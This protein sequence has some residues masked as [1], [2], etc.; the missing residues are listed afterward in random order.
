V[1]PR[2]VNLLA[3]FA[4]K[5]RTAARPAPGS[6]EARPLRCYNEGRESGRRRGVFD[7][8]TK[9]AVMREHYTGW[10]RQKRQGEQWIAMLQAQPQPTEK[11]RARIEKQIA[12][13]RKQITQ[14]EKEL[15]AVAGR[16]QSYGATIPS[17]EEITG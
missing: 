3:R 12:Q 6:L 10:A 5:R 14:A 1:T 4:N 13:A 15:A 9:I 7:K 16:L 8:G 2:S 17:E 11:E